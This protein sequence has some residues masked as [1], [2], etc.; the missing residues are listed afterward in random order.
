MLLFLS[1]F[2]PP[3]HVYSRANLWRRE[4]MPRTDT[5]GTQWRACLMLCSCWDC[6]E[7]LWP[8]FSSYSLS[9][10]CWTPLIASPL[11]PG[12]PPFALYCWPLKY[13]VVALGGLFCAWFPSFGSLLLRE[14]TCSHPA[15]LGCQL[16]AGFPSLTPEDALVT[17]RCHTLHQAVRTIKCTLLFLDSDLHCLFASLGASC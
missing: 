10:S 2:R 14:R 7:D 3:G 9:M 16:Q 12:S 13:N 5:L 11:A 6:H 17:C 1:W 8:F 4:K 15:V